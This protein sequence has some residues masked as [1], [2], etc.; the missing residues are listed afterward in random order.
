[1][2]DRHQRNVQSPLF[3]PE[4]SPEMDLVLKLMGDDGLTDDEVCLT[5][6]FGQG[7]ILILC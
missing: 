1:M 4:M 3:E 5:G 2:E 7:H 6:A